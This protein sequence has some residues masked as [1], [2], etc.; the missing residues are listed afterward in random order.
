MNPLV[1]IL[2]STYNRPDTIREALKSILAQTYTNFEIRL[3]RDGG[4]PIDI[5]DL[6]DPRL[7]FIDRD[8]N[9]GLAYSFNESI[10][11]AKGE[12]VCYLGDD[13]LFYP[14]HIETLVRAIQANPEYGVVYSDLYKV[15]YKKDEYGSRVPLAKNVEVNRD[16]DQMSLFRFNNQLHVSVLH[17]FDLFDKAGVYDEGI[18]SLLDWDMNRRM[19]FYT[20]FLHVNKVTGEYYALKDGNERIST[21]KRSDPPAFAR[22]FLKIRHTR[23]P[24]PW[25]KVTDLTILI[26]MAKFD[27]VI[28]RTL[29]NIYLFTWYPHSVFIACPNEALDEFLD[30]VK[31]SHPNVVILPF[32]DYTY[33]KAIQG[34]RKFPDGI[35][36]EIPPDHAIGADNIPW[37]EGIVNKELRRTENG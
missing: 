30:K 1:T 4:I 3:T 37:V 16:Y 12:Y 10:S 18:T 11:N 27:K 22:N 35:K 7:H 13:D 24:K 32:V 6:K 34:L 15:H 8:E 5:W 28:N 21:Q 33:E 36:V 29:R 14:D 20:D 2:I 31:T 9:K 26:P 17:R 23:P 25:P 19:C